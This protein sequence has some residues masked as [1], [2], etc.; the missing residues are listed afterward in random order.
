MLFHSFL[1]HRS[2]PSCPLNRIDFISLDKKGCSIIEIFSNLLQTPS[3]KNVFL[4]IPSYWLG[5]IHLKDISS[6]KLFHVNL[7]QNLIRTCLNY[8]CNRVLLCNLKCSKRSDLS[9]FIFLKFCSNCLKVV[10]NSL[11]YSLWF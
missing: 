9:L 11:R 6:K 10:L 7:T 2:Y 8:Q 5:I 1:Q 4:F 3:F